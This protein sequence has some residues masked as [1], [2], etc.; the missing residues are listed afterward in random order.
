MEPC[1]ALCCTNKPLERWGFLGGNVD[2]IE[3][4]IIDSLCGSPIWAV[5][6]SSSIFTGSGY[7]FREAVAPRCLWHTS[8][9]E[10]EIAIRTEQGF[11]Q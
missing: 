4:E 6:N 10:E 2:H 11:S 8:R 3:V 7:W 9:Q 5:G 1:F